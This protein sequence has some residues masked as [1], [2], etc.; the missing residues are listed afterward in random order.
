MDT[1]TRSPPVG[2]HAPCDVALGSGRSP[3]VLRD[4][5]AVAAPPRFDD[6]R[7]EALAAD[8]RLVAVQPHLSR[9]QRVLLRRGERGRGKRTGFRELVAG[10]FPLRVPSGR[11]VLVSYAGGEAREHPLALDVPPGA[12]DV[13]VT[14]VDKDPDSLAEHIERLR[15]EDA[16]RLWERADRRVAAAIAAVFVGTLLMASAAWQPSATRATVQLALSAVV[17]LVGLWALLPRFRPAEVRELIDF[18]RDLVDG[19]PTFVLEL[20]HVSTD[21]DDVRL[22]GRVH[23]PDWIPWPEPD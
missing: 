6:E 16:R 7:V 23:R 12:Y 13:T 3:F 18:A 8:G 19:T 17:T 4:P 20:H 11:L 5:A 22:P 10:R 1:A 9:P 21:V 2:R 14:D 15:G